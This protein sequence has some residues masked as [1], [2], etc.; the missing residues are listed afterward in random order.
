[1]PWWHIWSTF[2][3]DDQRGSL[4]MINNNIQRW[5]RLFQSYHRVEFFSHLFSEDSVV[6]ILTR[7]SRWRWMEE[8]Y[9][10]LAAIKGK[11]IS[12]IWQKDLFIVK[13][14]MQCMIWWFVREKKESAITIISKTQWIANIGRWWFRIQLCK[15]ELLLKPAPIH[16]FSIYVSV[17]FW[18]KK[19]LM[20][21]AIKIIS[22]MG[23]YFHRASF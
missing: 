10:N 19:I 20:I 3:C 21:F 5:K 13:K 16:R 14:A 1:M 8:Q 15:V 12:L 23:N 4:V 11:E 9:G 6:W 7:I 2:N 22:D 18:R 17:K